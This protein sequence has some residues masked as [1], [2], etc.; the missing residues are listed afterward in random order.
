MGAN[1][2]Y[3]QKGDRG[4]ILGDSDEFR[5]LH[6]AIEKA[7]GD[8]NRGIRNVC[9]LC[10]LNRLHALP[11]GLRAIPARVKKKTISDYSGGLRRCD[12]GDR[13]GRA[14]VRKIP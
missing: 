12:E 11:P 7:Q 8:R 14:E 6:R 3:Q 9:R 1:K 13:F 5:K 2:T 4:R 10:G